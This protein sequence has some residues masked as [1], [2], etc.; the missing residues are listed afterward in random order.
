MLV[1]DFREKYFVCHGY[2]TDKHEKIE[3]SWEICKHYIILLHDHKI[4][5]AT[6]FFFQ[7]RTTVDTNEEE[8]IIAKIPHEVNSYIS[9]TLREDIVDC[10]NKVLSIN[11]DGKDVSKFVLWHVAESRKAV[12]NMNLHA[13]RS[14]LTGNCRA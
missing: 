11:F 12:N 13:L 3:V 5:T 10:L 9:F 4:V 7:F 8:D 6:C 1:F 14:D 2:V